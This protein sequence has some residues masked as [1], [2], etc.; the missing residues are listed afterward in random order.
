MELYKIEKP[1][2][3]VSFEGI[4]IHVLPPLKKHLDRMKFVKTEIE[5]RRILHEII[6][7]NSEKKTIGLKNV[8]ELS[9]ENFMVLM[10][11]IIELET[12][13]LDLPELETPYY[14][15]DEEDII[16]LE[17]Q[18]APE[19]MVADYINAPLEKVYELDLVDYMLLLRDA[20]IYGNSGTEKGREYLENCYLR[21]QREPD[22]AG[23]RKAAGKT[24]KSPR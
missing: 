23:L 10:N 14:P 15:T 9:R 24:K 20:V 19:K 7:R 2:L 3:K 16:K 8:L 11:G 6:N 12:K 21:M 17:R 22:R 18:T 5:Q 1:T 4:S 13:I